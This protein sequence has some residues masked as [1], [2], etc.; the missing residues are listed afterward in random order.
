MNNFMDLFDNYETTFPN[1]E[2]YA[3][4]KRLPSDTI[5]KAINLLFPDERNSK[6]TP[7]YKHIEETFA[8]CNCCTL[9][10]VSKKFNQLYTSLGLDPESREVII[11]SNG[12][13]LYSPDFTSKPLPI[14]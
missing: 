13:I 14:K 10:S 11:T 4:G 6:L 3:A 9:Y 1:E 2:T 5:W 7:I 8:K 12:Y